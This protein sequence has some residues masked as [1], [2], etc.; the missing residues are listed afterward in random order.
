MSST[1]RLYTKQRELG[2]ELVSITAT[3]WDEATTIQGY[4]RNM[5]LS[6]VLPSEYLRQQKSKDE[7]EEE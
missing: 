1:L 4:I 5:A 2:Q 3:I 6:D 7:E